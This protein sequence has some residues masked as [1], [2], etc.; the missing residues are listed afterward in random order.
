MRNPIFATLTGLVLLGGAA[1]A[2]S[3]TYDFDKAA[4]FARFRTYTWTRGTNVTD[5][6]LHKRIVHAIDTALASKGFGMVES[7]AEADVLVAYH[8]NFDTELEINGTGWGPRFGAGRSGTA[9]AEEVLIGSLTVEMSEAK[10]NSIVWRGIATK[11]IDVRA[12]PEKRDK[13]I[14]QA[15]EKLFKNYPPKK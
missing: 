3:V 1:L 2:Q 8:A 10:S 4:N 12:K 7:G 11:E 5:Q 6:L 15:A 14:N 13:N 9:R